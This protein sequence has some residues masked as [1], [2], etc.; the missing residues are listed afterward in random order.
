MKNLKE[1][2]CAIT[3]GLMALVLI[4]FAIS[5]FMAPEPEDTFEGREF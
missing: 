4:F 3:V 2:L 1:K 5:D